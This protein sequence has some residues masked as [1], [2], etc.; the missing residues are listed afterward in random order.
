MFSTVGRAVVF[1]MSYERGEAAELDVAQ[2]TV[3]GVTVLD[4]GDHWGFSARNGGRLG[5]GDGMGGHGWCGLIL[6]EGQTNCL[7]Q[8]LRHR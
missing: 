1:L 2:P 6:K 3:A 8:N 5:C 7:P 4:R